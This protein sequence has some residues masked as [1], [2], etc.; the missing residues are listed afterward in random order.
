MP[1]DLLTE[2]AAYDW[3]NDHRD[4]DRE[5]VNLESVG[6]AQIARCIQI[7]H[8]RCQIALEETA[9]DQDAAQRNQV[10]LVECHAEMAHRHGHRT[11]NHRKGTADE[12]IGD[13][14]TEQR[15]EIDQSTIERGDRSPHA[16]WGQRPEEDFEQLA[17]CCEAPNIANM[18]RLE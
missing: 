3:R 1:G 15:R 13:E 4:L 16:Q 8:L 9:A 5:H 14:A 2:E 12:S 17:E 18:A 7:T 6:P 10:G 11:K